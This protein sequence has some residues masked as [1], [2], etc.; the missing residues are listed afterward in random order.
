MTGQNPKARMRRVRAYQCPLCGYLT[1]S[2]REA[3]SHKAIQTDALPNGFVYKHRSFSGELV[4][5]V[6]YRTT[7]NTEHEA[8][9]HFFDPNPDSSLNPS[10][11]ELATDNCRE[12]DAI[13]FFLSSS[14]DEYLTPKEFEQFVKEHPK[15]IGALE[16]YCRIK[17]LVRTQKQQNK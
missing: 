13:I 2:R 17:S 7:F 16:K 4:Y 9:H 1:A 5:H 8:L 15:T 14:R 3:D 11:R 10:K 12:S 6:I